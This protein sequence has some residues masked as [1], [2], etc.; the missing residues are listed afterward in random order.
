MAG[1][2][3]SGLPRPYAYGFSFHICLFVVGFLCRFIVSFFIL[4]ILKTFFTNRP[5]K[6]I[7]FLDPTVGYQGV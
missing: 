2:N 6:L 4:T 7:L 5:G 1:P 3:E